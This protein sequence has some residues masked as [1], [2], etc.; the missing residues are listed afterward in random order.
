M[1]SIVLGMIALAQVYQQVDTVGK[2]R[3][4]DIYDVIEGV[5]VTADRNQ[6]IYKIDR[7][8]INASSAVSAAGGTAIDILALMPSVQVNADGDLTLRG[9][10]NYMVYVDGKP[11]PLE[12][13]A[14][15]RQIPSGSIENIEI[16]TTPSARYRTDGD[17]GII[18]VTT[19]KMSED[20][21]TVNLNGSGSTLG[22]WGAD[23]RIGY[24]KGHSLWYIGGTAQNV[25]TKGDFEQ[26]KT[27]VV[28]EY[29]TTSRSDGFRFQSLKTMIG[30]GGWQYSNGG[31]SLNLEFQAG[32]TTKNTGGE[33]DYNARRTVGGELLYDND[34]YSRDHYMLDKKLIQGSLDYSWKMSDK[35]TLALTSRLRYD[36]YS[37]EYTESNMFTL[38]DERDEGTRGYEQEHHWD[39]DASLTYTLQY[40]SSGKLEAGYQYITYSEHGGYTF[41]Y[42]DKEQ[43]QFVWDEG[44]DI[45][46]YYRRQ[47]H[48]L[49]AMVSDRF[50]SFAFDAGL[51]ADRVLDDV[52]VD[53]DI[54]TYKHIDGVSRHNKRLDLFPSVHLSY[55]A[56]GGVGVFTF[57]YSRRTNRP[58]IWQLE[59]YITYEDYYTRKTGNPDILPEFSN[60]A[61]LS[62][63]KG[64]AGGYSL[65]VTGFWRGRTDVV[66]WVR[67]PYQAGIT[68]DQIVN[69]GDQNEYGAE[70]NAVLPFTKWWKSTVNGSVYGY[71]FTAKDSRC[72]DAKGTNWMAGWI[73]NFSVAR[74]TSLQ[75]D[76]HFIGPHVLTQGMEQAYVYFD[77]AVRQQIL[78][79]MFTLSAVAHDVLRTAVYENT[80]TTADL[81][82]H[83]KVRPVYPNIV[84]GLTFNFNHVSKEKSGAI[85]TDALFEGKA[86]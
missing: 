67:M 64:F 20:G 78:G 18:N 46:F 84:F 6:I 71:D 31:H 52:D 81:E 60:S 47:T 39:C 66:D 85:S 57:G 37:L 10:S 83:T 58:G 27:T 3:N 43:G 50:G 56:G 69:A 54:V 40:R 51:R 38:D 32:R 75:F 42:F 24:R 65:A 80:R 33:M 5:T 63:R 74:G 25:K 2:N 28:D 41:E 17:T 49:F 23:G 62:W 13:S 77:F 35:S 12:G 72:S 19:R 82:S 45:P 86:F 7:Q 1:L 68:L 48:S 26:D 11:S 59:P 8:T 15:L 53:C 34:Y 14:A 70:L 22:G 29:V 44:Q 61:E 16:I 79:G 30:L 73:N 55:D 36:P 76:G 9:S 21:L 4:Q